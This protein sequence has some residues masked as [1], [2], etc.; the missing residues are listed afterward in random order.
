M[1]DFVLVKIK[2]KVVDIIC[3]CNQEYTKYATYKN[4]KKVLYLE[5]VMALYGCMM[6]AIYWYE[7]FVTQLEVMRFSLNPYDP[8]VANMD[9]DGSQCTVC[10]YVD[11]TKISHKDPKVVDRVID[12][13]EKRFGKMTVKRGNQYTFVGMDFKFP[14][15]GKV[16]ISMK[17]YLRE[18]L[19]TYLEND[20][21]ITEKCVTPGKHDLFKTDNDSKE[22]DEQKAEIFHHLVAKLMYVSKRARLDIDLVVSFLC[23][24]V[25]NPTEQDWQKLRRLLGYIGGTIDMVRIMSAEDLNTIRAW[26]DA[27]Y[28]VHDNIR[29]HTG[30]VMWF[31][32]GVTHH[33]SCK[34]KLNAKS[35]TETEVIGASDYLPWLLWT[36]RF[37]GKQGYQVKNTKYYQDNESAIKMEKN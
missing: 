27:S 19:E 29:G 6:S 12:K 26:A 13:I 15:D 30:V 34:Q 17:E 11:D 7:T 1:K 33:K 4:G 16:E 36:K 9:I 10:W 5:L 37:M 3:Q 14:G 2:G 35:S 28:A 31:G 21:E 23:T 22:L 32:V 8:C 18:C 24:R 20:S 25:A